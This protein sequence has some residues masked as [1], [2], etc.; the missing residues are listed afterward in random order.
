MPSTETTNKVNIIIQGVF[1]ILIAIN[2]FFLQ[3]LITSIDDMNV[4][5]ITLNQKTVVYE[6]EFNANRQL[7]DLKLSNLN[8]EIE[9]L[10]HQY[11]NK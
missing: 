1:A 10:K 11:R 9:Q 5:I 7:Y 8:D 2:G 3:R 6:T 4:Q